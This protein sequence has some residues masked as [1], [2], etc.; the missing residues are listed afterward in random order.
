[1]GNLSGGRSNVIGLIRSLLTNVPSVV[2]PPAS[3]VQEL[4]PTTLGGRAVSEFLV[5]TT[6]PPASMTRVFLAPDGLPVRTVE[7]VG[8][9]VTTT[10][11]SMTA[12]VVVQVPPVHE[13]IDESASELRAAAA[14]ERAARRASGAAVASDASGRS[15]RW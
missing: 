9:R 3:S 14:R 8:E 4:G 11:T 15:G 7:T 10:D 12:P 5:S 1:M 2:L 13:T 6:A